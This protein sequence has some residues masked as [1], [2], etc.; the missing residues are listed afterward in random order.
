MSWGIA[1]TA[2]E[3]EK[4]KSRMADYLNGLNCCSEI[5]YSTYSSAFDYSM[6]LLDEMYELGRK[7]PSN[8]K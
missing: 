1:D 2:S 4:I 7:E 6:K 3:K 8:D 5:T